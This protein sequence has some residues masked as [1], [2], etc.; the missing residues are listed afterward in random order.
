[1]TKRTKE[2]LYCI[3]ILLA[4]ILVINAYK[5]NL[6]ASIVP[7]PTP[8]F[9]KS[10][11]AVN[12]NTGYL[13]SGE[14]LSQVTT[15][16]IYNQSS[17]PFI[18]AN[19]TTGYSYYDYPF[20][21]CSSY[22]YPNGVSDTTCTQDFNYV[23]AS[24]N[25]TITQA[26]NKNEKELPIINA[27]ISTAETQLEAV[28]QNNGFTGE[29]Y[30]YVQATKN[31]LAIMETTI[32]YNNQL[33]EVTAYVPPSTTSTTASTSTTTASTSTSLLPGQSTSSYITTGTTTILQCT[34]TS[35]GIPQ[36]NILQQIWNSIV[37]FF[38]SIG[39]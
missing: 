38:Q 14:S 2:L 27:T 1:M 32:A 9:P 3:I 17:P 36:P 34:G 8:P 5:Y 18:L 29:A 23:I 15:G 31:A 22:T 11:S 13:S 20:F 7:N 10:I 16:L 30:A 26:N 6:L 39:L 25:A 4:I 12:N 24:G 21:Y 28:E 33:K 35:C 37:Q 19:A